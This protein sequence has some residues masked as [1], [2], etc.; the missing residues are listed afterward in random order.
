MGL[1][2][3]CSSPKH[4][5]DPCGCVPLDFSQEPGG[6][7]LQRLH[8]RDRSQVLQA[9]LLT[10]RFQPALGVDLARPCEAGSNKQWPASAWKR[11]VSCRRGH[12]SGPAVGLRLQTK[13]SV[14]ARFIGLPQ[15][16]GRGISRPSRLATAGPSWPKALLPRAVTPSSISRLS[17]TIFLST[18]SNRHGLL[19]ALLWP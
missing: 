7:I 8:A 19:H 10:A 11:S 2:Q 14:P 6:E 17:P 18:S 9:D 16:N 3:R 15:A 1:C 13:G 5:L 12:Y 4:S